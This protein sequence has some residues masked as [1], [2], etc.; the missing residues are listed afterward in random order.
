MRLQLTFVFLFS[1]SSLIAQ[2]GTPSDSLSTGKRK[3]DRT[4]V[5]FLFSYY[6]QEG[7][8]SAVTGGTGTEKLSDYASVIIVNVPVRKDHTISAD[9]GASY[10]TSASSDNINPYTVS[11]AS[12]DNLVFKLDVTSSFKDTINNSERGFKLGVTHQNNFGGIRAGGFYSKQSRDKNRELKVQGSINIDKWA[13]YY[14]ISKLYPVELKGQGDLVDT[15]KRYS[16]N[17]SLAYKQILTRRLQMQLAGELIYQTGLLSTPFHRVYFVEQDQPKL[18]KLPAH[19][20]RFPLTLRMNYFMFDRLIVRSLYR[21]YDDDFGLRAHTVNLELPFKV[22]S[23][24]SLY[25][26]YNYHVQTA[27]QYFQ[28]YKEHHLTENYYTSDYDLSSL[29]SYEVGAGIFY[30]PVYNIATFRRNKKDRHAIT[31][32]KWELRYAYYRR[33]TGLYAN[34]VSTHFGFTF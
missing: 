22:T 18:E 16:Y 13:L 19:R 11:S 20:I 25:P 4:E 17:F 28:G 29:S 32:R 30:A 24:F 3:L 5:D 33:S 12:S 9:F 23:F 31:L 21:F 34:I 2:Q 26:F 14:S 1:I 27:A 7:N 8:N 10:Y 15:D 6:H